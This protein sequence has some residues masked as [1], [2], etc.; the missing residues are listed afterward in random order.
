MIDVDLVAALGGRAVRPK[1]VFDGAVGGLLVNLVH[2][3]VE[4]TAFTEIDGRVSRL[5]FD[6]VITANGETRTTSEL[7]ELGIFTPEETLAAEDDDLANPARIAAQF[8][9]YTAR[10]VRSA[11]RNIFGGG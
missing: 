5:R 10:D 11:L 8:A 7:H 1:D 9:R 6:Y 2:V 4:R 3:H